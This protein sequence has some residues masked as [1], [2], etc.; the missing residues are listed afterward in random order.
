MAVPDETCG[1]I[2]KMVQHQRFN[3]DGFN[4]RNGEVLSS[5]DRD[6]R[7]RIQ[8]VVDKSNNRPVSELMKNQIQ[9]LIDLDVVEVIGL[10]EMPILVWGRRKRPQL[11]WYRPKTY[12][13]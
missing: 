6:E 9:Q 8:K 4:Y 3:R 10:E 5:V 7:N 12:K 13:F 1:H 11:K 2:A